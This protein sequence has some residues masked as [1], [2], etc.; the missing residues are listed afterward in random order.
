MKHAQ[1]IVLVWLVINIQIEYYRN[2]CVYV[3][4]DIMKT[5]YINVKD[6]TIHAVDAIITIT[7]IN[8]LNAQVQ[9]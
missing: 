9:E 1:I 3:L 2:K 6:V 4:K 7:N 5:I 8:V